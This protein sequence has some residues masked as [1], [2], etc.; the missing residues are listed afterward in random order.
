MGYLGLKWRGSWDALKRRCAR[1]HPATFLSCS[2]LGSPS[3]PPTR[4]AGGAP[5]AR[6]RCPCAVR[7]H[8]GPRSYV[9]PRSA[10]S[11]TSWCGFPGHHRSTSFSLVIER[12]GYHGWEFGC[13]YISIKHTGQKL[14]AS[15]KPKKADWIPVVHISAHCDGEGEAPSNPQFVLKYY[16]G[17]L[18]IAEAK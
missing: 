9:S 15:T 10:T 8:K 4:A 17:T 5:V 2:Y 3:W 7:E 12:A 18:T 1:T 6:A 13:R 14:P 11:A 16:K